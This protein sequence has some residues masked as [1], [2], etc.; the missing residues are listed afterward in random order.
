ME[1][2]ELNL[3]LYFFVFQTLVVQNEVADRLDDFLVFVC[4]L[5]LHFVHVVVKQE[6]ANEV[7]NLGLRITTVGRKF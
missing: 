6:T 1:S 7:T 4:L 5:L 2:F 3:V